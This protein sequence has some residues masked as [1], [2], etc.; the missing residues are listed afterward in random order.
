VAGDRE[1]LRVLVGVLRAV[2]GC[3][4]TEMGLAARLDHSAISRYESGEIVP[5]RANLERM[6]LA[7][8]VPV[9]LLD[10]L[11]LP[12]IR[13]VI[14][15]ARGHL[16]DAS[17]DLTAAT[18]ELSPA[19]TGAAR[20]AMAEY[21]AEVALT[22]RAEAAAEGRAGGER[23]QASDRAAIQRLCEESERAAADEAAGALELAGLALQIAE[24]TSG[25]TGW[26]SRA[27]GYAWGFVG[28][29]RR[30]NGDVAGADAAFAQAW[31]LWQAGADTNAARFARWRLLD[32]E[33]SLRRDQRRFPDALRL[34]DEA[35]AAAP[36]EAAGRIEVKRAVT[37]EH[38]GDN[39]AA[40]ATLYEAAPLVEDDPRLAWGVRFNLA[41]NLCHLGRFAEA[42]DLLPAV[43]EG[44][45]ALGNQLDL[46]RARW[47]GGRVAAGRGGGGEARAAF[48]EVRR[49][50]V[51]RGNGYDAALVSLELAASELERGHTREV[52]ELAEEML[53]IFTAK[54]VQREAVA[55]LGV[56]C[57]AA[58]TESATAELARRT[59]RYLER[60][61][62]DPEVRFGEVG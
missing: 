18:E 59:L 29:A 36:Q 31:R 53:R 24:L 12:A 11:L 55:A 4:Q 27:Q 16:A 26:R 19:L 10:A 60:A 58:R 32:L 37:L 43:R 51:R 33:A 46:V 2:L 61:R 3:N 14:G 40:L 49:E 42:E 20:T 38:A 44:A 7:A 1:E 17:A 39:E 8:G 45:R 50:F 9:P 34:L 13:A 48:E 5:P 23:F 28:N 15:P 56:F 25:D 41:T 54:G 6:A 35:R 47:L 21:L 62:H 52:R 30:V 57:Q 22:E